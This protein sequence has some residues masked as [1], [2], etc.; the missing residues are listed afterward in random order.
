MNI[1]DTLGVFNTHKSAPQYK[2]NMII[3]K[4]L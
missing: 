1:K 3:D 4:L 2:R